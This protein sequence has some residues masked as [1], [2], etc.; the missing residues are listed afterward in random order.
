MKAEMQ[1][2]KNDFINSIL[3][4]YIIARNSKPETQG[5]VGTPVAVQ[6][7]RINLHNISYMSVRNF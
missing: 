3:K 7:S 5:K 6:S 1:W 4:I 2:G